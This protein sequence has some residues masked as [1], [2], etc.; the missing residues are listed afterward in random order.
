MGIF[1][2]I[3]ILLLP[4]LYLLYQDEPG[5]AIVA[6]FFQCTIIGWPIAIVWALRVRKEVKKEEQEEAAKA[7]AEEA[8]T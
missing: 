1:A 2:Y 3:L 7:E 6:L 5:K 4:W 8:K